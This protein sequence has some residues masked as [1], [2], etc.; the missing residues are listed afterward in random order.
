MLAVSFRLP[1][2]RAIAAARRR[3]TMLPADYYNLPPEYRRYAFTV[4]GL[5]AL[6]QI[7][8]VQESLGAALAGGKTFSDWKKAVPTTAFAFPRARLDL[9]F[10]Q[11]AQTAYMAGHFR[12]LKANAEIRPFW[13][14]SSINDNRTRP[15]HRAMNGYI[16]RHDD[17]VWERWFPPC[18]FNCRCT[19]IGLTEKQARA[20][21]FPKPRPPV[22]PDPG[23]SGMPQDAGR[24]LEEILARDVRSMGGAYSAAFERALEA[25]LR[26]N[27][28]DG[29]QI[30]AARDAFVTAAAADAR[31][32]TLSP[33]EAFSL[34]AYS[35]P[36]F[37][38]FAP[39]NAHFRG[40][41]DGGLSE[42]QTGIAQSLAAAI[43]KLGGTTAGQTRTVWR[44]VPLDADAF[45]RY[46]KAL[47]AGAVVESP[48][49]L[50]T[51]LDRARA[52][53]YAQGAAGQTRAVVFEIETAKGLRLDNVSGTPADIEILLAPGARFRVEAAS[54]IGETLFVRLRD[55][56]GR[57]TIA[58]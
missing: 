32:S 4:S 17:P 19:I 45:A 46:E 41:S 5:A 43:R 39:I 48:A 37:G 38:V 20:R 24:R 8:A 18:G 40:I 13:L 56:Q 16:A 57:P 7:A 31:L 10:R 49:F 33:A 28:L 27:W 23:F 21:G 29:A 35:T 26:P 58:I 22:E 34:R 1:P 9:I 53:G 3:G 52:I 54:R 47:V 14:Y 51:T 55:A 44:G 42:F 15:S 2:S 6:E 11:H 30:A 25:V 50:S 12:T 36:S